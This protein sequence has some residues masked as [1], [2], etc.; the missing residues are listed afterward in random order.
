MADT[1]DSNFD[2]VTVASFDTATEAHLARAKVEADGVPAFIVGADSMQMNPMFTFY[3]G[4]QVHL[5]V[6]RMDMDR[7]QE[8]LSRDHDEIA[9]PESGFDSCP[10]CGSHHIE[11]TRITNRTYLAWGYIFVP[12]AILLGLLNRGW[13]CRECGNRW[14]R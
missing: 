7:A 4:M 6:R 5:Q 9:S 10:R 8:L 3:P 13:R 1:S 11:R 14:G 12:V 2:L